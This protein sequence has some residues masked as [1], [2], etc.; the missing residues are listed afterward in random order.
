[1]NDS[2]LKYEY[3]NSCYLIDCLASRDTSIDCHGAHKLGTARTT[4][5]AFSRR[6]CAWSGGYTGIKLINIQCVW[7]SIKTWESFA[8]ETNCKFRCRLRRAA[9]VRA[10]VRWGVRRLSPRSA[11]ARAA[12]RAACR[13]C[14]PRTARRRASGVRGRPRSRDRWACRRRRCRDQCTSRK[15]PS[16]TARRAKW[17]LKRTWTLEF[18]EY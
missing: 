13:A 14:P 12:G 9:N 3:I 16:S 18:S 8:A 17:A 2:S 6:L 5:G 4:V 10:H 7:I 11:C 1:M 15:P